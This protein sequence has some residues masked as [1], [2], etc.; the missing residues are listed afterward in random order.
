MEVWN[1]NSRR[2]IIKVCSR[3]LARLK[4]IEGR[5]MYSVRCIDLDMAVI[6][7]LNDSLSYI[8]ITRLINLDG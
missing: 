6:C 4:V 5:I 3:R 2:E 7:Y 8:F 1:Y